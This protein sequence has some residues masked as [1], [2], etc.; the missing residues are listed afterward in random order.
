L[1]P[2][3]A[4]ARLGERGAALQQLIDRVPKP[5]SDRDGIMSTLVSLF[6]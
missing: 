5:V 3:V 4:V 1:Q 2:V 6:A